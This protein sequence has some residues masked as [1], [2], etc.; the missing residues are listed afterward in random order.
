MTIHGV[1]PR[2]FE[3]LS[4]LWLLRL[5]SWASTFTVLPHTRIC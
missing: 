3:R 4:A 1:L 2:D 5:I